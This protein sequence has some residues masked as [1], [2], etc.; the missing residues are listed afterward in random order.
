MERVII[1]TRADW[2]LYLALG[3]GSQDFCHTSLNFYV[4]QQNQERGSHYHEGE[5]LFMYLPGVRQLHSRWCPCAL[6]VFDSHPYL[7]TTLR[8]FVSL[9]PVLPHNSNEVHHLSGAD[10]SHH[11]V[12]WSGSSLVR[13]GNVVRASS[14]GQQST[15]QYKMPPPGRTQV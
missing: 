3:R 2:S 14:S 1:R 15:R 4:Y 5:L 11:L 7:D 13:I 10:P 9:L 8:I 6:T 12:A